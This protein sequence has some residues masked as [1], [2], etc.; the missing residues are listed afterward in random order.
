MVLHVDPARGDSPCGSRQNA[1]DPYA[2]WEA[3]KTGACHSLGRSSTPL[4]PRAS[5]YTVAA[6]VYCIRALSCSKQ[7]ARGVLRS[8]GPRNRPSCEGSSTP[9]PVPTMRCVG[10]LHRCA[11]IRTL[12][13]YARSVVGHWVATILHLLLSCWRATGALFG[14]RVCLDRQGRR[15]LAQPP[16]PAPADV[17]PQLGQ[18]AKLSIDMVQWRAT[19]ASD[20]RAQAI[21]LRAA[22]QVDQVR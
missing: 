15:L 1:T 16:H 7:R 14:E 22:G 3:G 2:A 17:H 21:E 12:D 13:C 11:R 6:L 19:P 8:T 5:Q 4:R 9:T 18:P 20:A 10:L